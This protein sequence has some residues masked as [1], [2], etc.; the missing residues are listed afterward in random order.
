MT[1]ERRDKILLLFQSISGSQWTF[2]RDILKNYGE[3]T[4][5]TGSELEEPAGMKVVGMPPH[6]PRGIGSRF[7]CWIRYVAGVCNYLR[8]SGS[9]YSLVFASTNPPV[10]PF[11][12]LYLKK[13]RKIPYVL[14][15]W[16]IYPDLIEHIKMFQWAGGIFRLWRRL[17]ERV[18]RHAEKVVTIGDVMAQTLRNQCADRSIPIDVIPVWADSAMPGASGVDSL[19]FRGKYG[20]QGKFIVLYSGKMGYG[21]DIRSMLEASARLKASEEFVFV[22]SGNGPGYE[23]V[24]KFREECHAGNILLFGWQPEDEFRSML[25]GADVALVSQEK[26]MGH[27]FMPSKTYNVM[28][29]GVPILSIS[30][31]DNDLV[32][33]VSGYRIG[34]N[35]EP[36]DVDGICKAL[37]YLREDGEF[38]RVCS[39]NAI[40]AVQERF[41]A[42]AVREAY[43]SL[44]DRVLA[45]TEK[46][47]KGLTYV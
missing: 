11:I 4:I 5:L 22:F 31:G 21:H 1:A 36:G 33:T 42:D 35:V 34:I 37:L 23:M 16:D 14:L 29:A 9:R 44:F 24:R 47:E 6:D 41:T 39:Q 46:E 26:G 3:L 12:A 17:N 25:Y 7:V 20:L 10:A 45:Q 43:E 15:V 32:R 27:L 18:Y 38:R 28:A 19:T 13:R 30:S 8:R 40:R 2:Y